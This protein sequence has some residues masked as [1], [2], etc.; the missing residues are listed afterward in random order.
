MRCK[1][2]P[3]PAAPQIATRPVIWDG[4]LATRLLENRFRLVALPGG[5]PEVVAPP[6]PRRVAIGFSTSTIGIGSWQVWPDCGVPDYPF[7][8]V[9][10]GTILWINTQTYGSLPQMGWSG[11]AGFPGNY[12][13]WEQIMNG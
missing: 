5:I 12:G 4:T 3:K 9:T 6:N 7:V 13:V 8:N 10:F 2:C 1:V 11:T